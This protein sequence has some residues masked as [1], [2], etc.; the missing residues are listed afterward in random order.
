MNMNDQIFIYMHF[1][2]HA[3]LDSQV[4]I[5]H[6]YLYILGWLVQKIYKGRF[7]PTRY[8]DFFMEERLIVVIF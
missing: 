1:Q 7:I 2:M 6:L 3:E 8:L 5:S 4:S